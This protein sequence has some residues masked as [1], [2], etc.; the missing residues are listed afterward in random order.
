MCAIRLVGSEQV[1]SGEGRRSQ[2]SPPAPWEKG[3]DKLVVQ[4]AGLD[5][6]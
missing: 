6:T 3:E 4:A 2:K 1:G 5:E